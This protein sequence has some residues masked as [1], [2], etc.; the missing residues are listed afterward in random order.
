MAKPGGPKCNLDCEYCFYREKKKLYP[1]EKEWR[2]S[3]RVL[4]EFTKQ[5]IESQKTRQVTFTWQGGEPTLLG[6]EFFI[7]ALTFQKKYSAGRTVSNSFQTNGILLDDDWA[8]FLGENG[9]LVGLSIDGPAEIHDKY[10]VAKGGRPTFEKVMKGLESLKRY[11]VDFNTLTCVQ[12]ENSFNALEV[13]NFLKNIGS[14]FLQFIPIVE[15][16]R[17]DADRS[18]LNL[19]SPDFEGDA[20]VTCWSVEPLQYG[21]FMQEIFDE[22]VRKDVGKIFVQMFDVCLGVWYG[23]PAA[24]CLFSETCGTAMALEH[25]GDLYSCDHYVYPQN[26][27]GNIFDRKLRQ[28][29]N[30]DRQLDFGLAKK[31]SLPEQCRNCNVKFICRGGCPK[32][33]F[34]RTDEGESGLNYLCEGYR[35]FFRHIDN[36]MRFMA[37]ELYNE[38]PPANVMKWVD[39]D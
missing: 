7:K 22:W 12:R 24:L 27:L 33:R 4:E 13:Y 23:R 19:V 15:R 39:A 32:N 11:G 31:K 2:M 36:A 18:R 3:D 10:R 25:N 38:R 9:F 17:K 29:A 30:S 1:N 28:M 26:K 6:I 37:N 14:Q 20:E 34:I 8:R 16:K 5:Y 35:H 21:I